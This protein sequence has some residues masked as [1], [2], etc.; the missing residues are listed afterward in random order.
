P[1]YPH[2]LHRYTRQHPHTGHVCELHALP[3]LFRDMRV[4]APAQFAGIRGLREPLALLAKLY[5][6]YHPRHSMCSSA[7]DLPL[8]FFISLVTG[9]AS[10]SG[11]GSVSLYQTTGQNSI[12]PWTLS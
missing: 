3:R 6:L 10:P 5:I 12:I 11:S 1:V 8:R 4:D 9:A 2:S 7:E